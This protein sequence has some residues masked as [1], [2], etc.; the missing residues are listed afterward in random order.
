MVP[1]P[2]THLVGTWFLVRVFSYVS[3]TWGHGSMLPAHPG[4]CFLYSYYIPHLM[5]SFFCAHTIAC[6]LCSL[7][8][9]CFFPLCCYSLLLHLG[10]LYSCCCC[11]CCCFFYLRKK[12]GA[13]GFHWALVGELVAPFLAP[14]AAVARGF[15]FGFYG[16][17]PSRQEAFPRF[18]RRTASLLFDS[19]NY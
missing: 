9:C 8:R 17:Y 15:G 10:P 18:S 7:S 12:R 2:H 11:C 16:T 3:S 19:Q 6:L 14:R 5:Y 1:L 4:C 13:E